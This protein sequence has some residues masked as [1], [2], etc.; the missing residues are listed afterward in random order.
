MWVIRMTRKL[1]S[2]ARRN[3]R[4]NKF[5]VIGLLVVIA[6]TVGTVFVFAQPYLNSGN[7]NNPPGSTTNNNV[8]STKLEGSLKVRLQTS[9]GNITIQLREDKPITSGNFKSIVESGLYDGTLF[10]RVESY[11]IQGGLI[12]QNISAIPDELEGNNTNL[13]GTVA[14]AKS[15]PNTA[16]SGFFINVVDNSNQSAE[17]DK[18]YTVFGY[19]IEG[20]DVVD[21]ISR[22]PVDD[23]YADVPKPI[24]DVVII[25]AEMLP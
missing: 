20:M 15:M 16:T 1:K 2:T 18:T 13:R 10:H 21:A 17:V 4:N 11:L 5:L 19:V 24:T 8:N 3:R 14:M 7:G 12:G 6:I 23:P 9:M 25:K 22:V